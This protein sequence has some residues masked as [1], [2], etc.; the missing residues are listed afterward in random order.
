MLIP[1]RPMQEPR[2][3]HCPHVL[4]EAPKL[5]SCHHLTLTQQPAARV[6]VGPGL[7]HN[8][9]RAANWLRERPSLTLA[10]TSPYTTISLFHP[11]P[12]PRSLRKFDI[13]EKASTEHSRWSVFIPPIVITALTRGHGA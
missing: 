4:N 9:W 2:C 7:A 1:V 6:S 5:S 11:P 3:I 12:T 10:T 13:N 8:A